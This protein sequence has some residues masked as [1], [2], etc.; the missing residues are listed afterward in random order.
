ML[1]MFHAIFN[2]VLGI[3]AAVLAIFSNKSRIL[4]CIACSLLLL[5]N[6]LLSV[7]EMNHLPKTPWG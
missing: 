6:L 5:M 2:A 1:V 4:F 3:G 7:N